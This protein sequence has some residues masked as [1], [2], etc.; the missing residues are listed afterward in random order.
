MSADDDA[1]EKH[2]VVAEEELLELPLPAYICEFCGLSVKTRANLRAHH[3]KTHRI[4]KSDSDVAFYTKQRCQITYVYHCPVVPCK[5]NIGC[6]AGFSTSSRLKQH[7]QNVHMQK[8]YKCDKCGCLFSTPSSH[9]YHMRFCGTVF[10]CPVCPRSYSFK[11]HLDQHF[12]RSGHQPTDRP[13]KRLRTTQPPA[14]R[15][16]YLE[17]RPNN[18][19]GLVSSVSSSFPS[20]LGFVSSVGNPITV[21]APATVLPSSSV[22]LPALI[23]PIPVYCAD[24]SAQLGYQMSVSDP[25]CLS[26]NLL[27][28]QCGYFASS[29]PSRLSGTEGT[30]TTT[31]T[32]QPSEDAV[33]LEQHP[34]GN[35]D[36]CISLGV[37]QYDFA[38]QFDNSFPSSETG[39]QTE[40]SPF[41]QELA[42]HESSTPS[43]S[44]NTCTD[45]DDISAFIGSLFCDASVETSYPRP[46]LVHEFTDTGLDVL[47]PSRAELATTDDLYLSVQYLV[48]E[49]L[50]DV[51]GNRLVSSK[52]NITEH[53]TIADFCDTAS[54]EGSA[55]HSNAH[56]EVQTDL[57]SKSHAAAATHDTPF[58]SNPRTNLRRSTL[59][60]PPLSVPATAGSQLNL[61]VEF[62]LPSSSLSQHA[63]KLDPYISPLDR[64]SQ[65]PISPSLSDSE[66]G[67]F[68]AHYRP[69]PFLSNLSPGPLSSHSVG[70]QSSPWPSAPP[71]SSIASQTLI[72]DWESWLNSVHTQTNTS[73]LSLTDICVG[74]SDEFLP[75]SF[76][77]SSNIDS[78]ASIFSPF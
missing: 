10:V 49:D 71:S 8:S 41:S 5:H 32:T 52:R 67:T 2:I 46:D 30:I 78:V 60:T 42:P 34:I 59:E 48:G 62:A 23:F 72:G 57:K 66:Y 25:A 6:G 55:M 39:T 61:C 33:K 58:N 74:A 36:L 26:G 21:M 68:G 47:D 51:P 16:P 70:L 4:L 73:P 9:A 18:L 56:A 37:T 69:C 19:P 1:Y 13:S 43:V 45:E 77:S 54:L 63:Q 64:S 40:V 24:E 38:C 76:D 11:K 50:L 22:I 3:V 75:E 31:T 12:R 29:D 17:I 27:L 53:R 35:P 28:T 65:P 44:V 7:Y 15:Q 20:R 14:H